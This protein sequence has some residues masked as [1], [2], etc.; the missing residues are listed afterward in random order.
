MYILGIS[1]YYHDA[2]A[3]LIKDG[4]IIAAAEEERF[5]RKKHD[6]SF[7]INAIRFCLKEAG[8]TGDKLDY[9]AFYEKPLLKFERILA[10]HLQAFPVSFPTF[11]RTIPGWLNEK[12]RIPRTLKKQLGYKGDILYIEHHLSHAASAFLVS[13]FNEAA[14]MTIDGVGEWATTTMGYAKGNDIT[15]EE[16]M[17]FPHSLGLLYSAFTAY[18]G[19]KVNNDEYKVMGLAAYGKPVY[20][21]KFKKIVTLL[22]D[23][24]YK[25]D[26]SYF[27]YHYKERMPGKKLIGLFGPPRKPG[28]EMSQQYKDIAASLQKVTEEVIYHLLNHLYKKTKCENLCMAG[29]VC[30]NSS[31]NGKIKKNTPFK[32]VFI[33]PAA[34]DAGASLGAAFYA[35]NTILGKKRDCVMEHAYL[36]PGFSNEEVKKFLDG[37]KINYHIFKSDDDIIKSTA[38][39]IW[40][41]KVVGW[42][43]GRMEWGPR[44]LGA[45]SILSNAT[46][47]NMQDILNLKVKH[48][49]CYDDKTEILTKQGW[50]LF[51]DLKG[52]EEVAT[53]NP[54]SNSL[55]YQKIIKKV[56]YYYSGEMVY[57]KNKRIDLMVTP[58]HRVWAKK[59]TNH[60]KDSHKK[61]SFGFE[62]AVNLLR[63]EHVQIKAVD[64]SEG[65]EKKLFVLPKIKKSKFDP[66]PQ[67]NKISMDLWLEFL[68]YY[69]SEGCFCCDKSHYYVYVSQSKKSKHF[70]KI[71]KCLHDLGF[72]WSYS[73]RSFRTS[74]KQLYEYV[75]QFGKAKDKFIPQELLHLSA[76]QLKILFG[77][78]MCGDGTY[79]PN[80]Y[81]Y[82]TTSKRL[83]DNVQ[84]VG[85]KLGYSVTTSKE[86]L[87]NLNHNDIYYVRLNKGSKISWVRK[88]QSSLKN[89]KGNVYCVSVPKYHILCIKRSEKVIFSGN[90]F[91]PFAPAVAAEDAHKYFDMDKEDEKFMLFVYP[92]KKQFHNKIPS[93]THEDGTGRLQTITKEQNHLY[94]GVIKEFG[95]LSGIPI[96]IN[97][98]FNIRGEP[99]VCTPYDAY[100]CMMGTGIDCLVMGK[101]L[102]SRADNPQDQWNSEGLAKD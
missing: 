62:Y 88:T 42:F 101:F 2:A 52:D 3:C 82:T 25:L 89:Y 98:S 63:K 16:E 59:I 32:N 65:D 69:L 18:L 91:R 70:Q 15:L 27:V 51:K 84:E 64:K 97:T 43:Q 7:P 11:F 19:F 78:L 81:K 40:D 94:H 21:G 46:N 17:N 71:K 47:P 20:Y 10:Q 44:A 100:R 85:L 13:P 30:L 57:F 58:N 53:L 92:I 9:V 49:E 96:I 23:G 31:A 66:R 83:A 68:G 34:S 50:K 99:I 87:T 29:G 102:I 4:K 72:K 80:Q 28:S 60:Q 73:N 90:S 55:E 54:R 95:R 41:N 35:Y 12:L 67:I 61:H 26:M 24:S 39:L 22:D 76:R 36:G 45:R 48:R 1:C 5:T 38:K 74:N 93:V 14:I 37:N 79:R 6:I 75:K 86:V 33:Q 8:I 56:E 77:A